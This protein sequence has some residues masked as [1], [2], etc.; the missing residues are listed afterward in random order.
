MRSGFRPGGTKVCVSSSDCHVWNW[1]GTPGS[2]GFSLGRSYIVGNISPAELTG[3]YPLFFNWC[4]CIITIPNPEE[5]SEIFRSYVSCYQRFCILQ[6]L[7]ISTDHLK[8]QVKNVN[9]QRQNRFGNKSLAESD[10]SGDRKGCLIWQI[11]HFRLILILEINFKFQI[12]NKSQISN[13]K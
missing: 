11:Q 9:E 13:F 5:H 7:K 1:S 12:S 2:S 10:R 6:Y 4:W 8:L 3:S